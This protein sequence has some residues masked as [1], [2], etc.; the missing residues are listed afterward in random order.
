MAYMNYRGR[1]VG[2]IMA[3]LFAADSSSDEWARI[4]TNQI[5]FYNNPFASFEWLGDT[6]IPVFTLT[7]EYESYKHVLDRAYVRVLRNDALSETPVYSLSE[8]IMKEE[9]KKLTQQK[10]LYDQLLKSN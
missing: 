8:T 9:R 4:G 5:N 6:D 10:R 7:E 3:F 1:C 2:R